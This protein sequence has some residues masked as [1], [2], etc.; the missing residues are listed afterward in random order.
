MAITQEQLDR[1]LTLAENVIGL[2]ADIWQHRKNRKTASKAPARKRR[3]A[4]TKAL[5]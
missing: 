2:A 4:P 1:T 5:K 3:K